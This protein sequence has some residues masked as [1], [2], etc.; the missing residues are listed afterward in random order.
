VTTDIIVGFPGESEAEFDKG[1]RFVKAMDFARLHVFPFS[2]RPGTAAASMPHQVTGEA[3]AARGRAMRQLSDQ[4]IWAFHRRFVGR[5]LPVLWQTSR[6]NG[7]WRGLT[8]NYLTVTTECSDDLAN[9]IL[10]TRMLQVVNG[11][12]CGQVIAP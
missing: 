5:T 8:D 6:D 3:K 11:G 12:L 10:P 4:Q 1:Y 7:V 9:C 2:T